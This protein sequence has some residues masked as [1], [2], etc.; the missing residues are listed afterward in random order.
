MVGVQINSIPIKAVVLAAGISSRMG[1]FKPLLPID[2]KPML[3]VVLTRVLSF[4]FQ[5]VIAVV[6]YKEHELREAIHVEDERLNWIINGHFLEGLSSS[7]KAAINYF[8]NVTSGVLVFLGD[9]PLL[10]AS[11][12][13]Q[14]LKVS[15]E[16]GIAQSK[17]I[18]QPTYNGTP[19][20]PVFIS[21]SML[22]YLKTITGD[23]GAK[24]IFKFADQHIYV[25]V[26]DEGTILDVD[27][28][29]DYQNIIANSK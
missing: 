9:Q 22:P 5:E 21:S 17:C 6:G 26:D 25:S 1:K 28:K 27:T 15:I 11:T 23:Q 14:I 7:I 12:I 18:I 24:P 8:N 20:H 19:G 4:P 16:K 13:D 3:E 10:K 2:G 29:H